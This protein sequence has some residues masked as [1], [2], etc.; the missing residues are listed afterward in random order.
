VWNVDRQP[1]RLRQD[2]PAPKRESV[3]DLRL[4]G[5]EAV[6]QFA[7]ATAR[8]TPTVASGGA[9]KLVLLWNL[10]D[11]LAGLKAGTL[12]GSAGAAEAPALPARTRLAGHA[13]TVEDVVFKPDTDDRLASVGDDKAVLFWDARAGSGPSH[14][15]ARAH[16]PADI[17][18]VDWSA[19]RDHWVATGDASGGIKVWDTRKLGGGP[20][21][22]C[23]YSLQEHGREAI[24]RLEW[25]PSVPARAPAMLARLRPRRA[26]PRRAHAP[27]AAAAAAA[28]ASC[29][30]RR[31]AGGTPPATAR[32]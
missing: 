25:H 1:A 16:G 7:L 2:D 24:L 12:G 4:T 10:G 3:P 8:P 27:L 30:G 11:S 18:A 17:Q 19:L 21:A 20:A 23:A 29:C 13:D 26:S 31:A 22:A 9:D 15:L 32:L 14:S 28:A 6:A 5:H